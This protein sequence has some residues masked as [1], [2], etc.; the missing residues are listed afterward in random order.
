MD[1]YEKLAKIG[2]GSYGVVLKCRHRETGQVVAIKK[3][4]ETEDDAQIRKIALREVRMLKH[5]KHGN[6]VNLIEVFRRKRKLHLVFEYIE[7]T[8]LDELDSHPNG[9]PEDLIKPIFLQLLKA[10]EYCHANNIIHRDVKPEN[11]LVSKQGVVKLCDFGFA[12]SL[13][14]A[15]AMYTDYVATRWYRSPELL[16]GDPN[17][18]MPVDLWALGCL[19]FEMMTSEPLFPGDSDLDQIHHIVRCFGQLPQRQIDQFNRNSHLFS[20]AR[21]PEPKDHIP[22]SIRVK[23]APIPHIVDVLESCL[24]LDPA[25]RLTSQGLQEHPF[26]TFD[27]FNMQM[28]EEQRQR[29]RRDKGTV[30]GPPPPTGASAAPSTSTSA[31]Q[32]KPKGATLATQKTPSLTMR[33]SISENPSPELDDGVTLPPFALPASPSAR[34]KPLGTPL[35]SMNPGTSQNPA[36]HAISFSPNK[37][38]GLASR[39]SV[40]P[41]PFSTGSK[42]PQMANGSKSKEPVS[43]PQLN[44]K[45]QPAPKKPSYTSSLPQLKPEP[46]SHAPNSLADRHRHPEDYFPSTDH[47]SDARQ[48]RM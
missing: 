43:L 5:L 26:F 33:A 27:S 16:V 39:S 2:E 18:S 46:S 44:T 8:L 14:G 21:I 3:F 1:K 11:I 15:G 34:A 48:Y 45:S 22:L 9:L 36:P 42:G 25:E 10:V 29:L 32:P 7:G 38:S 20:G 40:S 35:V 6:L 13:S 12:R 37:V 41:T 28:L 23:H 30:D 24:K 19:I 4:L 47:S 17:Y 31:S